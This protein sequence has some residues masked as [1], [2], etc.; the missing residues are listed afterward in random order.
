MLGWAWGFCEKFLGPWG[1]IKTDA[2]RCVQHSIIEVY[3]AA[4]GSL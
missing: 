4:S 2:S 1:K 3:A